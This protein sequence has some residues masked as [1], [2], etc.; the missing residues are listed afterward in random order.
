MRK[1]S[2]RLLN[3]EVQNKCWSP[4][5]SWRIPPDHREAPCLVHSLYHLVTNTLVSWVPEMP[6]A[7]AVSEGSLLSLPGC[8]A[9][10][11]PVKTLQGLVSSVCYCPR[12]MSWSPHTSQGKCAA[13]TGSANIQH[14]CPV[15]S[16]RQA[17]IFPQNKNGH[18]MTPERQVQAEMPVKR[19][20]SQKIPAI[21]K[22][23]CSP[24]QLHPQGRVT[25]SLQPSRKASQIILCAEVVASALQS[26]SSSLLCANT[27]PYFS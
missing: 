8:S 27:P 24:I 21:S 4:V 19:W 18:K 20:Q 26:S 10:Q 7:V 12:D 22:A 14:L 17:C 25:S 16:F 11:F 2:I 9:L 15:Y 13:A 23:G 6:Q 1:L 3:R 5:P